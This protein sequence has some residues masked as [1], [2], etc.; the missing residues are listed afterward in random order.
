[1][2]LASEGFKSTMQRILLAIAVVASTFL[3]QTWAQDQREIFYAES[4]RQGATQVKE[5]SF[6]AKL[7]S[8]IGIYRERI[9]DSR[10]NDR[11][12]LTIIP[13]GPEGDDKVTS[14]QVKLS[15][16]HHTIYDNVLLASQEPSSDPKNNLWW[17]DPKKFS[18]VPIKA[19]RIIKVDNFYVSMQVTA[20]H[21]TP[22]DSPYLDS[23]SVEVK[24][25]NTDPRTAKQ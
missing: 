19:R 11:Y 8:H 22:G 4:F 18:A 9:K 2:A 25:S 7:D 24:F 6:E 15:D 1:M 3:A 21:F 14:W 10:G 12:A 16:L 20:Y 17:L 23:M 13:Q 5:E